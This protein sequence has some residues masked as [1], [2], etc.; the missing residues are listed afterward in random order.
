MNFTYELLPKYQRLKTLSQQRGIPIEPDFGDWICYRG[1]IG[2][3]L[4][5]YEDAL[6]LADEYADIPLLEKDAILIKNWRDDPHLILL[7]SIEDLLKIIQE[8]SHYSP[9]LTPEAAP[10]RIG[11]RAVHPKASPILSASLLE[12]LLDLAILLLER[13]ET[14]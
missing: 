12:A 7:P 10:D 2:L 3:V 5:Y 14:A 1:Q 6:A 4:G 8:Y 11:W 9:T 13:D